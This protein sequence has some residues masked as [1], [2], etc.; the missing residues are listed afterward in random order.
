MFSGI[1]TP[2]THVFLT[3]VLFHIVLLPG[4]LRLL[5]GVE[6]FGTVLY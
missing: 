3:P 1:A 6:R 5:S 4:I 2:L